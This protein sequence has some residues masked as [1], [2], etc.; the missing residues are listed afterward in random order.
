[1]N[2]R[3][4]DK[5]TE[6]RPA[7]PL[8]MLFVLTG[9]LVA[10]WSYLMRTGRDAMV[11]NTIVACLGAGILVYLVLAGTFEDDR[12]P[13]TERPVRFLVSYMLALCASL[14]MTRLPW[15]LWPCMAIFALMTLCAGR[16]AGM[17]AA[18]F[19]VAVACLFVRE[20]A[21][22]ACC[23][24]LMAGGCATALFGR[25]ENGMRRTDALI[26]ATVVHA[27]C[28]CAF[29]LLFLHDAFSASAVWR[30]ATG[31]VINAVCL[32]LVVREHAL[33]VSEAD[34]G[35][36]AEINDT[37]F[38]LMAAIRT[39]SRE[40]YF[41]A[42]HTAYLTDRLA[43]LMELDAPAAKTLAMYHRIGCLD[44]TDSIWGEVSH[45]FTE[46]EFP[47]KACDLLQEYITMGKRGPVTKEATLVF[48]C[49]SLVMRLTEI[50]RNNKQ[51]HVNYD[52]TIERLF[53]ELRSSGAIDESR[54]T[55]SEY[56]RACALLKQE[57]LYY[58]LLR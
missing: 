25:A 44:D 50:F 24:H 8:V 30:I 31:L 23:A 43:Q 10:A 54:M 28:L 9:L 11:R 14:L 38:S 3:A 26:T 52:E 32:F 29:D 22:S 56:H 36:Y 34:A 18:F 12:K 46:F 35:R 49:E 55:I 45:Y 20:S 39:K 42:I 58:D 5:R 21:F 17:Y 19:L 27:V 41:R 48:L 33:H 4:S 6:H 47:R 53:E 15:Q 13:Y 7:A 1:M 40:E 16:V 57:K 51:A 37:E 2:A